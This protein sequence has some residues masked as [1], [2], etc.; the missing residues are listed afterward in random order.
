MQAIH[1]TRYGSP[2]VLSLTETAR[3]TLGPRDVLVQVE[4]T[5]VTRGD[6]RVRAADFPGIGR[7][8]GRL[9]TGLFAPRH[10]IPGTTFAG[11]VV[12]VGAEVTR[13]AVGDAVFGL[14]DHGA[15]AEALA[16]PEDGALAKRPEGYDA[17]EA[18]TLPYG[19]ATAR[20]FLV[21]LAALQPGERVAVI[22][23]SG[24]VGRFAVALAR[25]LGAE[26]TAIASRD[27]AQLATLGAHRVIDRTKEDPFAERGRYDVV[28]DTSTVHHFAR[29]RHALSAKGRYL[30]LHLT[31]GI[32]GQML[33]TKLRGG[34]R[35]LFG[36]SLPNA[37]AIEDVARLAEAGAFT[38]VVARRFPLARAPEAHALVEKGS[39]AGSVVLELRAA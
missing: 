7:L 27:F 31:V 25:H 36:V 22:G 26:V 39:L 10:T 30:T 3:P 5:G 9:V 1:Q 12:E 33:W 6:L 23:A 2:D 19:A 17:A 16:M 34:V 18:T 38:P 15:Y 24:E 14:A 35:A 21:E 32:L 37:E 4:A 11:R 29:A 8:L 20:T 28:F 13:F